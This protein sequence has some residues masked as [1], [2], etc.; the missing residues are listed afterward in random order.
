MH[1]KALRRHNHHFRRQA[2]FQN[3]ILDFICYRAKLVI[4]IDGGQHNRKDHKQKDD[5]RD[6]V[7]RSEG[8]AVLRFWNNEI[9]QNI[10][11]VMARIM[12]HLAQKPPPDAVRPPPQ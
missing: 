10:E 4:E 9:D 3:Y 12:E 1:L 8:F 7:L 11:G 2:P 5:V 6:K